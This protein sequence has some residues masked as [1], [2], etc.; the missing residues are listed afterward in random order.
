MLKE[1][2]RCLERIITIILFIDIPSLSVDLKRKEE[3]EEREEEIRNLQFVS[4]Q[5]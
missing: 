3:S 2:A 1:S 5:K 4:K